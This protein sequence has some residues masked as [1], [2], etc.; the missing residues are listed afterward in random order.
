MD[1]QAEVRQKQIK[2]KR[3]FVIVISSAILLGIAVSFIF[4][5]PVVKEAMGDKEKSG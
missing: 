2:T 1:E 4:A 3:T 5:I